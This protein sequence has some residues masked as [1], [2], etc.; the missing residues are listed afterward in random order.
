MGGPG[1]LRRIRQG[2]QELAGIPHDRPHAP[3]PRGRRDSAG[4]VGKA[5]RC[6]QDPYGRATRAHRQLAPRAGVGRLGAL[7]ALRG[8]GPH[9]VRP[10]D[11]GLLDLHRHA[12]H[13][14]GDLRDLRRLRAEALRRLAGHIPADL[15]VDEARALRAR[16]HEAYRT[17]AYESIAAQMRAMLEFQRAGAILFDYGNNF[18][19]EAENAG[20]SDF[21]YPGFVP[22]FIRPLFCE[23]Q[24]PFR[25]VA[26][27]GDPEDIYATDRALMDAMPENESLVRW[28][29]LARE[30][31]GFQG[32]PA[33]ICWL[34]Y[35]DRARA[36]KI[37][38]EL[39]A[40][41]VVK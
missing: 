12:G 16:D 1:R 40:R 14:S 31:V 41:G 37:F 24:G 10:D 36:G 35:G 7:Q 30:R 27:S 3:A 2:G 5:R 22:E 4:P 20:V 39:V 21:S 13:P 11:G 23:G 32:L 25:W 29:H 19:R 8:D 9:H 17:R 26:L 33:R 6:V 38:N 15:T 28:L 18:R 34:G